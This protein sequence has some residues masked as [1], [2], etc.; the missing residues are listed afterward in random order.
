MIAV[1]SPE[2][3]AGAHQ[4]HDPGE[5]HRGVFPGILGFQWRE[6]KLAERSTHTKARRVPAEMVLWWQ[7][8]AMY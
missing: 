3:E 4:G 1:S 2:H 6:G 7:F 5:C 8:I